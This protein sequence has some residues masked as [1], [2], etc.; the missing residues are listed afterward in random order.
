MSKVST[1]FVGPVLLCALIAL[2][3]CSKNGSSGSQDSADSGKNQESDS[4]DW[5]KGLEVGTTRSEIMRDPRFERFVR[6]TYRTPS[7][8]EE[9]VAKDGSSIL[10]VFR[11]SR[12]ESAG[13]DSLRAIDA[14]GDRVIPDQ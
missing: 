9:I 6:V 2:V 12:Y 7:S 10:A 14:D 3:G 5:L 4:M 8:T 11:A 1:R 13:L